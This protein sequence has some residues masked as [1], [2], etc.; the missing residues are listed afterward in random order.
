MIN[1]DFKTLSAG[2]CPGIQRVAGWGRWVAMLVVAAGS[3]APAAAFAARGYADPA[4]TGAFFNPIT[5][6][7]GQNSV[8]EVSFS[9]TGST[10]IPGTSADIPA[11]S[12]QVTICPAYNYYMPAGTPTYTPG[13]GSANTSALFNW[14][15]I[16]LG[17]WR[18]TNVQIIPSLDGGLI[19][20]SYTGNTVTPS[21][22]TTNINVQ[23]VANLIAFSNN[24]ANDNLQP[25][26][27]VIA[28]TVPT[29]GI[30]KSVSVTSF[31]VGQ[32][33][34]YTLTVTNTGT[35]PTSA[36]ATVSDTISNNLLL[37][38]MP[39]NCSASG[40]VVTCTI[41]AGLA[42]NSPVS[43]VIPVTPA[44]AAA[45]TTIPNT[46][47]VVGGGDPA[48]AT[49]CP[50][51]TTNTP[52]NAP[53]LG[54]TKAASAPTFVVGQPA[55]YTLTVTNT[56]S[57]P[58]TS[59]ATV[60]DTID[61]HLTLGVMPANCS[62][63][64]QTVTC[65][66]AAGLA[67][68][69]PVSFVIPVTP[70]PSASGLTLA[71]T[72]SVTGGD[73]PSCVSGC[74]SNTTN[75]PVNAPK[76]SITKSASPSSFVVG[77]PASYI[78]TVTNTGTAATTATTTVT[79]T[80]ASTLT[81]GA[82]PANCS[83]AGQVVT[84]TIAAG[85]ATNTP[86]TFTIPVTPQAAANGTT[87]ANTANVSGGGDPSCVSNCP[88][89]TTNTPVNAPKL[90]IT[91]SASP[92]SFV[93]GQPAS[94]TLTV[95]NTGS[96]ATTAITTVSD[97]FA[98]TLT[99][100]AMPPNCSA[101]GQLVTCTIAAGLAT[102]TPV[103]FTIPV[104]PQA[105][106]N[107]TTIANTANVSGGGDPSCAANC[108]S[109]TTNTPVNAPKLGITKSAS[110]SSFV[111]GQPA[112]YIL[113]VT[114]T[115]AVATTD[116]T[117][118]TDTIASTLTLGAMPANC[119]AAG[120]VVTCTIAAGLAT[121]T[122]VTFTI[123]VTPQA[124][125]NGTLIANTANVS[126]GGDPSCAT[127]C[128]S[129]T[130]NTPV[131]APKLGIT[132]SA[133]PNPFVVGQP[134]SYTLTVTNTGAVATTDVTTVTDTIASTLTLGAM[135]ANCSA[136]GQVVT[137]T[138][139]AGLATNTPVTFTIPVTPQA[140]ANGTTIANTANVS[141]GGDPS[142]AS[143]CPS[144]TT[145]TP[146][147]APKLG[148]TKSAS[149][150]PFVVGQPASYT[151]TVTNTGAVATT[152]VTTVTDTI[153]STLTLGAMPANCSAAGQAVTCTIAAGL[154]ANA[155][156]SFTIPVT[157]QTAAAGTTIANTANVTGGGD[158]AC[159]T[160]C[161]SNTT[162]TPVSA[163]HVTVV[164]SASASSFVVNQ[165]A[166]YTLTVTNTGA[167]ATTATTTVSDTF[168][169]TLTLGTMPSGCS[170]SGQTVTCTIS[171]PF[172]PNS[173]TTFVIPVTPQSAAAGTTI[174][175]TA[176]VT[177]GGDPACAAA[178]NSNTV[179]T[180]VTAVVPQP[181]KPAPMNS[182]W[183]LMLLALMLAGFAARSAARDET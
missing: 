49:A 44:A 165:S 1:N 176:N 91:K 140:A 63:S 16:G 168:A 71:N 110:P 107:N 154:A 102:N 104:T 146:V 145:N 64:G 160:A 72:A 53:K 74:N 148:I 150:N 48:C 172:A 79:D 50:S 153:A 137:C 135:P 39:P 161:N 93:V 30:T 111:V 75:T 86:V 35:G 142:C 51:N 138:I 38:T 136:A 147:N 129:N 120:Q 106:A 45:G 116:V 98:S 69:S 80:I 88:S 19:H 83:A 96:V 167:V 126:G 132:K 179:N 155:S 162:N 123:P 52:V 58:T 103:S 100:G 119:S 164:K 47:N 27:A 151:L 4:V 99:L 97:S 181:V 128:P 42:T 169:S 115:G 175:N 84:C 177:G 156:T 77:Q 37:G 118:V 59:T 76:L 170:A 87:I 90:S 13:T 182:T 130:T 180:P 95:T 31:Q 144:N 134:A 81:L 54:I 17:C 174:A 70:Q 125:A 149:P 124:A 66:I 56:G 26:L 57:A 2:M 68:G 28:A 85:L 78:L 9:N 94:Y 10:L 46:A 159:A 67:T 60:S 12:I 65:T 163:P 105:A 121:N 33:A 41:A 22:Q 8:L 25:Q 43:F 112:S 5:V 131:N 32:P 20:V 21:P 183:M 178:C 173:P 89:N 6:Q 133:S 157:P 36:A 171:A 92:S 73:D 15:N 158:P 82:M 152:A 40:Q 113:T 101:S 29:L 62:A 34:T 139:A 108:P 122:P 55:S 11:N 109:N 117:T 127:A 3:L 143:N 7:Q 114:N 61:S 24:P 141:G 23:I 18:G 166:S 14:F